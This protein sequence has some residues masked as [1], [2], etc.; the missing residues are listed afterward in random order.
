MNRILELRESSAHAGN[1]TSRWRI[2]F[3]ALVL[4]LT[5]RG[6]G[7]T[8]PAQAAP[9]GANDIDFELSVYSEKL[10]TICVNKKLTLYAGVSKTKYKEELVDINGKPI[11]IP[12]KTP[13]PTVT[14]EKVSGVGTLEKIGGTEDLMS[15]QG[16]NV[17]TFTSNKPG[18]AKLKFTV[19]I[20]NS[21]IGANEVVIGSPVQRVKEITVKVGCKQKVKTVLQFPV[22]EL[23]KITVISDDAVMTADEAGTFTGSATMYWTYSDIVVGCG[24]FAASATD[25]Q[26]D[27]TGNIDDD[28]QQFV[29]TETFQ[30][31]MVSV[32]DECP[33]VGKISSQGPGSV[34][35]L[36]FSVASSGGVSI[37]T[38]TG[39]GISGLAHIVVVPEEDET[40]AFI[41]GNQ[42]ALFPWIFGASVGLVLTHAFK[43]KKIR[44]THLI[45]RRLTILLLIFMLLL[46]SCQTGTDTP[47]T[48]L[49]VTDGPAPD[50][51][52]TDT[53]PPD[54]QE[55]D[56]LTIQADVVFGPG[57]FIFPDTEAGL[58]DLSSYKATLRLSFDGTRDG[59]TE[60]WSK[61]YVMLN[62][63]E[64]AARQLT[65]EQTGDVSAPDAVFIAEVDG[66]AYERRGE[67]AC[68]ATVID[69]ENSLI[70]R[71]KP[72]GLLTGVVGA[73]EAGAETFNDVA[74]DHYTFD[75]RAFGQSDIAQST[76]EMWVA[77]V[78]GYIVKYALTTKGDAD[79]FGEG[80]EGTLTWDYELTEVNRPV[81][82]EL[83][84]DCPA[85]MVVAP[86]LPDASNVLNMPSVLGY[87]TSTS[88][89]DIAAFYQNELPVLDWTLIGE[90][91]ITETTVLL[92]F[93]QG[94]QKMTVIVTT[95]AGVTTVNILLEKAQE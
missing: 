14:G 37:Q 28:G 64:P 79:Y 90:P 17:F 34:Y 75:E 77:S 53:P 5:I 92:D 69:Q 65:I 10:P 32:S 72:V 46:A 35:P 36:T 6:A 89:A 29:A 55:S 63:Q 85:G 48:D 58:A 80:I 30:P 59:Q 16:E 40:A 84:A 31:T 7:Q 54:S 42:A 27:L 74:S 76:G 60:Q 66:A 61:T 44:V 81:T 19:F 78:G 67:N 82:F 45:S 33:V 39:E 24:S 83:P 22:P 73:E 57:A 56:V 91:A 71:L 15:L 3:I 8:V 43:R 25:S 70:E 26:V 86:L 62:T 88:L 68:N 11:P 87:D 1:A 95:D 4:A 50:P 18:T 51:Q 41:P 93:T 47:P 20:Q 12:G 49:Q 38:A 23:Y 13:E 2:V 21:W 52:V 94:N 9:A